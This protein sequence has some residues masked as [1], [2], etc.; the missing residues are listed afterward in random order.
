MNSNLV[1]DDTHTQN[2]N[3]NED[4]KKF[5]SLAPWNTHLNY[6]ISRDKNILWL[7]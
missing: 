3:A 6:I 5:Q 7:K 1:G 2:K 4:V